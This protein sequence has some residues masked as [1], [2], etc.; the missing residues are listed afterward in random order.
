MYDLIIIGAGPAGLSAAMV[1]AFRSR[2]SF[3]PPDLVWSR[4]VE[5]MEKIVSAA[6]GGERSQHE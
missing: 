5:Q 1:R 2:A 4:W 6:C 3:F